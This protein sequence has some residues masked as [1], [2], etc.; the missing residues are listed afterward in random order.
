MNSKADMEPMQQAQASP[1]VLLQ[2]AGLH[3]HP[4]QA[5][6][7]TLPVTMGSVKAEPGAHTSKSGRAQGRA[8]P[9]WPQ[10]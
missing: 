10:G 7:G 5:P 8:G 3:P 2:G 4:A 9:E 6:A 1:Q